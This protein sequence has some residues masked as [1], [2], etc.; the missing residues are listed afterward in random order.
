MHSRY[1]IF[2]MPIL[3]K[4]SNDINIVK[5]LVARECETSV[6]P[7]GNAAWVYASIRSEHLYTRWR[8]N[9]GK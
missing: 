7:P 1:Y 8:L 6:Y 2:S 9:I 4:Q 3:Y 5:H